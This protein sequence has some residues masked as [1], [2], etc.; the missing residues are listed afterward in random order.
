MVKRRKV[1]KDVETI[2]L[3]RS[4]RRCCLC[5]GLYHEMGVTSGQIV[6]LDGDASNSKE[7]NLA[8][9]CLEHHNQFDSQT[10]QGKG[11]TKDEV[12]YYRDQLYKA[13]EEMDFWK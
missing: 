3:V 11:F 13:V 8:F 1:P 2:V 10:S 6:H 9:L 4:R 5:Y 7:D 12:V